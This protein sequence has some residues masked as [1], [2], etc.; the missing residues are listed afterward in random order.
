MIARKAAI[1]KREQ[2]R[3]L[4]RKIIGDLM[5]FA[6]AH[7]RE[8][9]E[10]GSSRRAPDAEVDAVGIQRVQHPELLRHLH[11]AVVR[12]HHAAGADPNVRGLRGDAGDENLRRGTRERYHPV[13]FRDPVAL[14]AETVG[15]LRQLDGVAQRVGGRRAFGH[16]RLIYDGEFHRLDILTDISGARDDGTSATRAI[17]RPSPFPIPPAAFH[18]GIAARGRDAPRASP[19]RSPLAPPR[20]SDRAENF[21]TRS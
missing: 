16:R 21:A 17:A 3:H 5:A 20:Q 18:L 12:Q 13:M 2:L 6:I 1:E 8:S 15:E 10:P 14:V 7:Q 19:R 9:F 11:R 4:I